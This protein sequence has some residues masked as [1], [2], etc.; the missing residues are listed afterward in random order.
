MDDFEVLWGLLDLDTGHRSASG[1]LTPKMKSYL[2]SKRRA[3]RGKTGL[4]ISSV[5]R[6]FL[7]DEL[8]R[9][10]PWETRL[11]VVK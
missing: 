9:T 8:D 1:P 4:E 3:R 2:L 6:K 7:F 11:S 5:G 10:R